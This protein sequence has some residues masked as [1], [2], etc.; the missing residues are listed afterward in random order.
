ML[1][2]L[3]PAAGLVFL[4]AGFLVGTQPALAILI[5]KDLNAV[6]DKLLTLGTAP[7]LEWLDVTATLG[8]S[9]NQAE[10]SSF[11]TAQGFRHAT[12]NEV[13]A[14]YTGVGITVQDG[15]LNGGDQFT[16][17]LELLQKLGYTTDCATNL[18]FQKGWT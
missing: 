17:A 14:L 2:F 3:S 15:S 10:L 18:P 1:K 6:N 9:F 5:E 12:N 8:L 4:L 13:A 7:N 11:V 16:G